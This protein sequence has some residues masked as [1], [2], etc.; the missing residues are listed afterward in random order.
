MS[1]KCCVGVGVT[2]FHSNLSFMNRK[3]Y[4]NNYKYK[5]LSRKL[6][7]WYDMYAAYAMI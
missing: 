6:E 3:S 2:F 1:Y 4:K 5:E 7:Y